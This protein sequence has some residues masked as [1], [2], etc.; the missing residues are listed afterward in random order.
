[1]R[2]HGKL[3]SQARTC[4]LILTIKTLHYVYPP[5]S[6]PLK[7]ISWDVLPVCPSSLAILISLSYLFLHAFITFG[8]QWFWWPR[9]SSCGCL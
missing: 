7:P 5:C 9:D 3:E 6:A 1:V 8:I 4:G 2:G